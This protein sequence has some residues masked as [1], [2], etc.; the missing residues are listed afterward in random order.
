MKINTLETHDR[1]KEFHKQADL[2]AQGCQDCIN[3][4]P[5]SFENHPFYIFY[6]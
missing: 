1:L 5:K 6:F 2:I 3:N 4:R